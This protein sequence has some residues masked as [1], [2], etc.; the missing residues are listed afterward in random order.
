MITILKYELPKL[1]TGALREI[2]MPQGSRILAVQPQVVREV[3]AGPQGIPAFRQM[4]ETVCLWAMS[5]TDES[6]KVRRMF[7]IY[8]TGKPIEEDPA[9][10]DY[11]GTVQTGPVVWHV[12]E[13]KGALP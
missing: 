11:I 2:E 12:F 9:D 5:N 4:S 3:F 1:D 8:G 10:L 6:R 13:R 7:R